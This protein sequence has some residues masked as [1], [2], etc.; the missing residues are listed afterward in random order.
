MKKNIDL[1][2]VVALPVLSITFFFAFALTAQAAFTPSLGTA[3]TFGVLAHTYNNTAT[4]RPTMISVDLGYSVFLG[5]PASIGGTTYISDATFY[6]AG[7]DQHNALAVLNAQACTF[8]FSGAVDLATDT[9]HGTLGVYAPGVY[10]SSGKMT[11][12]GTIALSGAGTY[13]F[14]PAGGLVTADNSHVYAMDGASTCDIFWTP[15]S[16]DTVIGSGTTFSG[17]V[18]EPLA[19]ANNNI[20]VGYDADWT[21]RALAFDGSVT[22]NPIVGKYIRISSPTC[23]PPLPPPPATLHIIKNVINNNGGTAVATSAVIHVRNSAGEVA[24]SPHAGAGSPG[25][26]YTLDAGTYTVSEDDLPG[27]T[28]TYSG[29]CVDSSH[30]PLALGNSNTAIGGSSDFSFSSV[31]LN[32][33]DNKTCIITNDDIAPA[34]LHIIKNVINDNG[35]TAVAT[36]AV[37]HVRNGSGEVAGSPHAGAGSPGIAYT[38]DAGTYTVSEDVIS[39]YAATFSGSCDANGNIVLAAGDNKTC[40]ITNNDD[41]PALATLHIIKNVINNNG[42]VAV[43]SS[44]VIHVRDDYGDVSGSPHAGAG[45]PG[46]IYSLTPGRYRIVEDALP[47]YNATFSGNCDNNGSIVLAAGEIKACTITNDDIADYVSKPA[48]LRVIKNVI[49]DNGGTAVAAKAIIHVVNKKGD[50]DGSPQAGASSP[51]TLYTLPTG[52][53][54]VSEDFFAGYSVAIGGD[55]SASGNVELIPGENKTCTITN[56]DIATQSTTQTPTPTATTNTGSALPCDVCT[57]LSYD[58]YII[59]PDGSQRHSDTSWVS[60]TDRGNGVLR[61]SFEDKSINPADPS[62]DYNDSVV[63]VNLKNCQS[64]TFMFVSSDAKWKHQVR[65][66]VLINGV[67]KTDTLVTD[68]S[69]RV[70]GTTKT[71]NAT[72]GLPAAQ[73]CA[74]TPS[75]T[76]SGSSTVYSNSFANKVKG[77]ILLQVQQNGEAWY[78]DPASG[79][80]YYLKDGP[81]AYELMR[82]FGLGISDANLAKIPSVNNTTELK[83][84]VSVCSSNSLANKL[85]G[86]ILLQVQQNGEAWYIDVDKCRRL[87]MKD[88]AAAYTV[89]RFL[90]LGIT[91]ANLEKIPKG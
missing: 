63:D 52:A 59:N 1:L 87:Y 35:G 4:T 75:A 83:Q 44:A 72:Q 65:F 86:K 33:G 30:L 74:S 55:C 18:I 6:Q 42:G 46:I 53:Y 19:A 28:K 40:V 37:I 24:G 79:K 13:I 11:V 77:K 45:S 15:Q 22:T 60:V 43:A 62:F 48:T 7:V 20:I 17:T 80:R 41:A 12:G 50:V 56:D 2:S 27:Y 47:G 57:K 90:G 85:K 21:G 76:L 66:R 88:G 58:L 71:I 23:A 5:S 81:A 31:V 78:V 25:I 61:Y 39:G 64:V 49:N 32:S 3:N 9:S 89:M 73:V 67:V 69:A 82:N 8:T 68:D 36:S 51:G 54:N 14:R 91:D 29:D 26:A 70:T 38:L 10:C 84:S 16:T 34:T